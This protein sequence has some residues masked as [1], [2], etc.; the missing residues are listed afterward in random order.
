MLAGI[1][2]AFGVYSVASAWTAVIINV[3]AGAVTAVVLYHVGRI[4]FGETV[5]LLT[6]W[7]WVV[8]WMYQTTAFSVSLSNNYLAALGCAA[9]LL[10]IPKTV[11]T[12]RRWLLLGV[13]CGLLVLLQPTLLT[14]VVV[15]GGWLAWSKARSPRVLMVLLDLFW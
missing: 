8:P 7:L 12:S 1:F 5:G 6:A 2:K 10:W 13:Y 15:Y 11:E 9:L 3:L 14:V 4:H